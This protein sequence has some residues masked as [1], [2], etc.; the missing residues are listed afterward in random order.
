MTKAVS[1]TLVVRPAIAADADWAVPLLFSAGPGLFSYLFACPIQ[2]AQTV[3]HQAFAQ[4]SH[5]F[6]YEHTQV[7]E[8]EGV[9]VAT[10]IGYPSAI[11]KQADEKVHFVMARIIPLRKLPKILINVADFSR[12]KQEVLP[13]DYYALGLSV[14][15]EVQGL[16]LGRYLLAQAEQRARYYHCQRICVDVAYVNTRAIH[17]FEQ[18]GFQITCSKTSDRFQQMTSAGGIHRMVKRLSSSS[19]DD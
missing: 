12:I 13:H 19:Y 9:P 16:G 10:M 14:Q 5:A 3:L 18:N 2:E 15:A 17:L 11:K 7:V 8:F 6:S 4:P 1:Q